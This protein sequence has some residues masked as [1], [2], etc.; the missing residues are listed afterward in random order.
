[1]TNINAP[2]YTF[3]VTRAKLAFCV[4]VLMLATAIYESVTTRDA[5]ACA[6]T[7]Q[8]ALDSLTNQAPAGIQNLSTINICMH[9]LQVLL[10]LRP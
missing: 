8:P 9:R 5:E 4:L 6:L 10:R 2:R 7:C 3:P 1:M